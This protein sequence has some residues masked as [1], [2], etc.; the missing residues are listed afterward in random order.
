M[1]ERYIGKLST[2]AY[3]VLADEAKVA[4]MHFDLTQAVPAD[5]DGITATAALS[6]AAE[7][8][9][10]PDAGKAVLP[11]ART[12]TVTLGGTAGSIAAKAA[13]IHGKD[14]AGNPISETLEAFTAD[15]AG[16]KTSVKAFRE[17]EKV[18]IDAMD[19]AGVTMKVGWTAAFGLPFA[20]DAK[21][22]V[23]ALL[24]GALE[25]TA[26]TLTIDDDEVEKNLIQLS[27]N[28]N[29]EKTVDVYLFL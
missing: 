15:T 10:L 8:V 3:G 9:V 23:F 2:D 24:G 20:L 26:P 4:H 19:G 14:I 27:G 13:T 7:N 5:D 18:T 28:L 1:A 17:I 6:N 16:A 12:V 11:S 29:A 25:T 21:P 22:L